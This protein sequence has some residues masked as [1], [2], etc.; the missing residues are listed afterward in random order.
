MPRASSFTKNRFAPEIVLVLVSFLFG[1]SF[2]VVKGA[3][4]NV[5]T[6][7]FLAMRFA[8]GTLWLLLMLWI[9]SRGK[10]GPAGHDRAAHVRRSLRGGV[11]AGVFL[12]AGYA[13]Q[14]FGLETIT[15]AQSGFLTGLY[16]PLV[17]LFG[18]LIYRRAPRI[19]EMVGVGMAAIGM[20]L[21]TLHGSIATD[22]F[23]NMARG[24]L[25]T[26]GCA[27]C[28]ACH[29]LALERVTSSG[30]VELVNIA[31]IATTGLIA[32]STFWW[33]ETPRVTWTPGVWFAL[34]VTSLFITALAF[35]GQTWAQQRTTATRTA[36]ILALEP[37]FA[38]LTSFVITGESL[39]T[40]ALAGAGLILGGILV[41]ELK[42]ADRRA[43]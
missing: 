22:L 26:V 10:R 34:G 8:L 13:F 19:L 11:F 37:V 2:V 3:L 16:I 12:F 30:D 27:A 24:D 18:A 23:H 43:A 21:L 28:F 1:A 31:Q 38:W 20:A 15:P 35:A 36:L 32:A 42:P 4:A 29:I 14:T 6:L 9:R 25:L 17:P 40:R 41:V 7:L 39:S 5:S 33:V